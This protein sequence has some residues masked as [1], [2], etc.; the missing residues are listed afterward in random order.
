MINPRDAAESRVA[1]LRG[2][3]RGAILTAHGLLVLI[4]KLDVTTRLSNNSS[5]DV[6]ANRGVP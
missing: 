4:S 5:F 1:E 3:E 6:L 2:A